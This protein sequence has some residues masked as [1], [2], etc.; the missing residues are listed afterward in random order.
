MWKYWCASHSTQAWYTH[1]HNTYILKKCLSVELYEYMHLL[2]EYGTVYWLVYFC[3]ALLLVF[4]IFRIS[5]LVYFV[6]FF[7][8]L[9]HT[10]TYSVC[11][12][13]NVRNAYVPSVKDLSIVTHGTRN[14][15][16]GKIISHYAC[17]L[18]HTRTYRLHTRCTK[19]IWWLSCYCYCC[20]CRCYSYCYYYSGNTR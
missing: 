6:C 18:Y 19:A 15:C 11:L 10:H 8:S 2:F 7:R 16:R 3:F 13:W 5:C 20:C 4:R 17:N 12:T 9:S 14:H 1:T